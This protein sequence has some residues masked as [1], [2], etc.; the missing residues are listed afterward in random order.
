MRRWGPWGVAALAA[1]AFVY[2]WWGTGLPASPR[3]ELTPELGYIWGLAHRWLQ[4][5]GLSAWN[6]LPLTGQP[7]LTA[8]GWALYLA[9]ALAHL[10]SGVDPALL[11]KAVHGAMSVLG[12]WGAMAFARC[13]GLSRPAALTAGM[14]YACFPARVFITAEAL[15][16]VVGWAGI[17]W[18][19]WG[20]ERLRSAAPGV[21]ALRRG[22][23]WALLLAWVAPSLPQLWG[24][25]L[26]LLG[27][28]AALREKAGRMAGPF[29]W[30]AAAVGAAA[31]A[32]LIAY[33]YVPSLAEQR[34]LG[35]GQYV[36]AWPREAQ[37]SAP[38]A[39]LT[40]ALRE[41]LLPAFAP[42]SHERYVMVADF[43][44]YLGWAG[45]A[46]GLVGLGRWRRSSRAWALAAV[47]AFSLLLAL[48]PGV[49]RNPVYWL[50]RRLP[51]LGD[52]VR[53]SLRGLLGVS[54]ALAG[55]AALGVE[56]LLER[57][58]RPG[59]RWG[60]AGAL[61]LLVL[62]DY[63]PGS[64]AYT[65]VPA[66]LQ[67][68]EAAAHR[69][70]DAQEGDL[71]YW[72]PVQAWTY[73]WHYVR[74]SMGATVNRHPATTQ[75][76]FVWATTPQ[77]AYGVLAGAIGQEIEG[78]PEGL[79][80]GAEPGGSLTLYTQAVLS[81]TAT[82]YGLV[83]RT[84]PVYDAVVERLVATHGWRVLR[85]SEHVWLLENPAARPYLQAYAAGLAG[86]GPASLPGCLDRG[87]A[88]VAGA[89]PGAWPTA[90]ERGCGALPALGSPAVQLAGSAPHRDRIRVQVQ[91]D[92]PFL[93]MAAE[94]W[95]PH[96]RVAV[97]GADA[98]L[99]RLNG[100][101]LGVA[102][103]A[104]AR[105][106]VFRYRVPPYQVTCLALSLAT[107]L[108]VGGFLVGSK[109]R[110]RGSVDPEKIG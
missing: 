92:E 37:W 88:L 105:E 103:P 84:A 21:E 67:D 62:V 45:L 59:L 4:G 50:L 79:S 5:E 54:L 97:D 6:H 80:P 1:L 52:M 83:H 98:P 49:P 34:W 55:L 38:P 12:A 43:A 82:R 44:F 96:W 70:L 18:G 71:R 9:M 24:L 47:L 109:R 90:P 28:Y 69:W 66:Y 106:V 74:S 15:F 64:L 42:L 27:L 3:M 81:L 108:A 57:V 77:P 94:S 63:W 86:E 89:A 78:K 73:G 56:A 61:A 11:L 46:L 102:A 19:F 10:A 17:P 25:Q 30:Q 76:A 53:Y 75:D 72:V 95:Y 101:F 51:L 26:V 16:M 35:M 41:R 8:R 48:G 110:Q 60:A 107:W 40:A 2:G 39:L 20:W 104:G 93:L 65:T 36:S 85:Q 68:D 7:M 29:P 87:Y 91:A 33:F 23:V 14:V 13:L 99:L 32:G 100:G 58:R 31:T 22:L